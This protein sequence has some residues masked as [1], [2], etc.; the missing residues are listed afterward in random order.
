M[1]VLYTNFHTS[2][3]TGGHT[4]YVL[5][6]AR[7][8]SHRHDVMVAAP[9]GSALHR[10]A[11]EVPGVRVYA[12]SF[13]NRVH[14]VVRAAMRLRGLIAR[15]KVEL[16]HVNGSSDHR[17][18]MLATLGMGARR[19]RI[20]FTKHNDRPISRVGGWLR[21]SFGTDHAIGVCDFARRMLA[22]S[23]YRRC[24]LSTI[25]NGVDTRYFAPDAPG[26]DA[27]ALRARLLRHP[28]RRFLLG[29]NAGTDDYK[30]WLDMVEA[31][32]L[33]PE[34]LRKQI[35]I[36]LAGAP[37]SES[38][39]ARIEELGMR[40]HVTWVGRLE[41]VRAF[42]GALDIGF[43]LSYRIETI[44]FACR[45]MMSM[46]KPVVVSSHGGLPENITPYVDGW[47]VPER[48]AGRLTLLLDHLLRR[49]SLLPDAGAAARRKCEQSFRVERFVQL[50]EQAYASALGQ[51]EI[52][53][54]QA[55][56]DLGDAP[57]AR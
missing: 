23:P 51:E 21:A 55:G 53:P 56:S 29:S 17:L 15:E 9:Q 3:G 31:V 4:S 7:A 45:E 43:V 40:E 33:L 35:Q 48:D 8:L 27:Q 46:G 20:V 6:L 37:L 2:T 14:H 34:D 39:L 47:V 49:P 57:V 54:A 11:G 12:Q 44:S 5:S 28:D 26:K 32:S 19:P 30:G 1:K 24:K 42:I 10:R 22:D 18:A 16:V 25:G 36:A 52:V 50:T 13:P 38:Q 41:D